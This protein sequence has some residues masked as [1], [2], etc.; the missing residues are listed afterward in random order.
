MTPE[1]STL[2]ASE[3]DN[4]MGG[5]TC[6]KRVIWVEHVTIHSAGRFEDVRAKLETMA[7]RISD[8]VFALLQ[9]GETTRALRAL[10][11]CPP[12]SIFVQRDHGALLALAGIRRR[13]IQ[14]DLGNPLTASRMTRHQLSAGLYAPVRV[15]LQESFGRVTFE[16]DRPISVFRQFGDSE[17]DAV[18]QQLDQDLQTLLE[19][20]AS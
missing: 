19:A 6:S 1:L 8:G 17:I 2:V 20:A 4:Q 7:P 12:L 16:Y 10:E 14:Y 18:A 3:K 5:A 11:A 9:R 15:L 13:A